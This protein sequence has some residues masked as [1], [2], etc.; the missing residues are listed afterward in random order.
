V[1]DGVQFTLVFVVAS[2]GVEFAVFSEDE[3]V[4]L[5]ARHIEHLAVQLFCVGE[6][7]LLAGVAAHAYQAA[8]AEYYHT[9]ESSTLHLGDLLLLTLVSQAQAEVR[10]TLEVVIEPE[11]PEV[12]IRRQHEGVVLLA[13]NVYC[14]ALDLLGNQTCHC[15]ACKQSLA[16]DLT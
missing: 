14:A 6:G 7:R 13:K 9:V 4:F 12:V 15:N 8:I 1:L 11:A 10:Q 16:L 2:L 3:R 5:P